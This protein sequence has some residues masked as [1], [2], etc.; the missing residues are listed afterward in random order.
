[1]PC[2]DA[3]SDYENKQKAYKEH[4]AVSP[5]SVWPCSLRASI[6]GRVLASVTSTRRPAPWRSLFLW[7]RRCVPLR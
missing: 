1:M 5:A 3:R 4:G 7:L 2:Y 6:L